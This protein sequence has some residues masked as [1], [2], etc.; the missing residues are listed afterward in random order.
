M[1]F[2]K[3]AS[4]VLMS[5][6]TS[7]YFFP[8]EFSFLPGINTKMAMAGIGLILLGF[9]LA[10]KRR[11]AID[12]DFFILSL[13]AALVS[14]AGFISVVI[15]D[16]NDYT[17]ASYIISMWV[18]LSAAYV[19]I[20]CMKSLH[21]HISIVLVCNYL[22]AVCVAQCIVAYAIDMYKPLD[23][24]V[25]SFIAMDSFIGGIKGRLYGIGAALDVAGSRFAAALIM[26]VYILSTKNDSS[27]QKFTGIYVTAFLIIAIIGNIIARTTT[28]GM[29]IALLYLGIYASGIYK[30]E[31]NRNIIP[32]LSWFAGI[33][34][35][36]IPFFIY[37][38]NTSPAFYE[39]IR[40][41]F[42]GFF[43]L[44]EKG[45]WEV[46]S[47]EMLMQ[48]YI[49]PDNLKTWIIGDGYF[50]NPFYSPSEPYYVGPQW[51]GFY[52]NTD[53]GYSRFIFYF[54]IT[55]LGAFIAFMCKTSFT[56]M[57]YSPDYKM[58]FFILL[59]LN[60]IIWMKVSTDIFLVFALFLAMGS[61]ESQE[62]ELE[63]KTA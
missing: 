41:G 33:L 34:I 22:I 23:N 39:N 56:C 36:A 19:V 46:H 58:M 49:F 8:F 1:K 47:N 48:G 21:G 61:E 10:M 20:N 43:S 18:W 31:F 37:W 52:M 57:N 42:E 3:I 55:G 29:V 54:G 7:L 40:F 14:L 24:F 16:T 13:Y 12:K 59:I 6:L 44:A 51:G 15:N 50:N 63:E 60:F 62:E 53:V 4:I 11:S 25:R 28:V 32:A 45:E 26:I 2:V 35:V 30:M 38:Y 27:Q 9:R 17:Y 5:I